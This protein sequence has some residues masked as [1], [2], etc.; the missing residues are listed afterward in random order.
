M[1]CVCCRRHHN[2]CRQ[3][4][5][6]FVTLCHAATCF[7]FF[8]DI[9]SKTRLLVKFNTVQ[10][11]LRSKVSIC[12]GSGAALVKSDIR[13]TLDDEV[14]KIIV[15]FNP[16]LS[17]VYLEFDKCKVNGGGLLWSEQFA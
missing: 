10:V 17:R 2:R 16:L 3:K 14:V 5:L 15:V 9:N 11:Q 7:L 13:S 8:H 4:R 6:Q 12:N 1:L